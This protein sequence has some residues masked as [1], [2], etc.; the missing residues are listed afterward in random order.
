MQGSNYV[1]L[2]VFSGLSSQALLPLHFRL[3][4]PTL[5]VGSSYTYV[6][7]A[8][9]CLLLRRGARDDTH[10]SSASSTDFCYTAQNEGPSLVQR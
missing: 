9:H 5:V 4:Y 3:L 6:A 8:A 1:A 7:A 10:I 2:H